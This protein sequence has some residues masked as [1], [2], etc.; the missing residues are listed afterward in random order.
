MRT[1]IKNIVSLILFF[2]IPC[3]SVDVS[4][5]ATHE[6]MNSKFSNT[7][8]T[9]MLFINVNLYRSQQ[10][11]REEFFARLINLQK[12]FTWNLD[13]ISYLKDFYKNMVTKESLWQRPYC[14]LLGLFKIEFYSDYSDALLDCSRWSKT[15]LDLQ[16]TNREISIF[17]FPMKARQLQEAEIY[18]FDYVMSERQKDKILASVGPI[19]EFLLRD[20]TEVDEIPESPGE[21]LDWQANG[22]NFESLKTDQSFYEKNKY[23]TW[24]L[25][26]VAGA[27]AI[28]FFQKNDVTF[29]N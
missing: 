28:Q 9:E 27:L 2:T 23:L 12:K 8:D 29:S 11:S 6:S 25:S 17:G 22:R 18:N 26:L 3:Y 19:Q 16:F 14:Q 5:E 13:Q 7:F 15:K 1:L 10:I 21:K 4:A 24:G 20:F